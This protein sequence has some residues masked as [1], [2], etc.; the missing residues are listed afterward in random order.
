MAKYTSSVATAAA[1]TKTNRFEFADVTEE[2][3]H[4]NHLPRALTESLE[5]VALG[6]AG[7]VGCGRAHHLVLVDHNAV[8]VDLT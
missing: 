3:S 8:V 5:L 4:K 6:D 7:L 2:M 1:L